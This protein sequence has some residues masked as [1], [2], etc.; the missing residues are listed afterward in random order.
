MILIKR[1]YFDIEI[2]ISITKENVDEILFILFPLGANV[3]IITPIL[4]NDKT[5]STFVISLW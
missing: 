2:C 3:K 5:L 4:Y 1:I